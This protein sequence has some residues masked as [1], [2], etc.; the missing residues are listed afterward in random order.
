MHRSWLMSKLTS[1]TTERNWPL[2]QNQSL[3]LTRRRSQRE[4]EK[5]KLIQACSKLLYLHF[6]A[7]LLVTSEEREHKSNFS[8]RRQGNETINPFMPIITATRDHHRNSK[9]DSTNSN[10][11]IYFFLSINLSAP[12]QKQSKSKVVIRLIWPYLQEFE[13]ALR[14]WCQE[15]INFIWHA[16]ILEFTCCVACQILCQGSKKK[17]HESGTF[18][19]KIWHMLLA[20]NLAT[21]LQSSKTSR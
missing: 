14:Q 16:E 6:F 11:N 3:C 1:A 8:P 2:V 4:R 13:N 15:Y 18:S 10:W 9:T 7:I 5:Q 17:N 20:Q 21:L 19:R 12:H